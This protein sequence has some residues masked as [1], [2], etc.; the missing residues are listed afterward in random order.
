MPEK[1]L[2]VVDVMRILGLGRTTVYALMASGQLPVVRPSAGS[3]RVRPES[4]TRFLEEREDPPQS[5]D[6][7]PGSLSG[8][9][10]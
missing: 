8:R 10:R 5:A 2:S 7:R 4:L 9:T 6:L 1:L 3:V